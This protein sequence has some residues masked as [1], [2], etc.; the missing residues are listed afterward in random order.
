MM[1]AARRKE[2]STYRSMRVAY[3]MVGSFS[4]TTYLGAS[5]RRPQ[6]SRSRCRSARQAVE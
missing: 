1:S 5:R 3:E 2:E 4:E 6:V